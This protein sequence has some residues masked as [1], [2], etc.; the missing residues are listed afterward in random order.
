MYKCYSSRLRTYL[1]SCPACS[2]VRLWGECRP[3]SRTPRGLRKPSARRR[4]RTT[5]LRWRSERREL[6]LVAALPLETWFDEVFDRLVM[7]SVIYRESIERQNQEHSIYYVC[8]TNILAYNKA[9]LS[10]T[11]DSA[12]SRTY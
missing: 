1:W 12:Q 4:R 6:G 9:N 7:Q 5:A 3:G 11:E 8:P 10:L 2:S